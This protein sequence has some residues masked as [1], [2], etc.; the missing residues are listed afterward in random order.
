MSDDVIEGRFRRVSED[1][2]ELVPRREPF[3]QNPR[4]LVWVAVALLAPSSIRIV[5]WLIAL[6]SHH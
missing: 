6:G 5:N 4:N 3:F 2:I 1:Q